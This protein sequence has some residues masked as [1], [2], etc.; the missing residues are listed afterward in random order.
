MQWSDSPYV[1]L[2]PE[3]RGNASQLE[4]VFINLFQ[5]SIDALS[6]NREDARI[7]VGFGSASDRSS[8]LV[9]FA[10]TGKGIQPD[11]LNKI[12]EPFYTTKEVGQGTGL[13]LSIVYGIIQE[14]GGS[15][16]CESSVGKGTT[17]TITLPTAKGT[18]SAPANGQ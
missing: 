5:T 2:L 15:I 4:Q 6:E 11:Q 9:S 14:H 12:F 13:G 17:L 3:V 16:V 18:R 10:D 1:L 7:T 8:V